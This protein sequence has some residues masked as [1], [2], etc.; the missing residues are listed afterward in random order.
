MKSSRLFLPLVCRVSI[1]TTVGLTMAL[2][3]LVGVSEGAFAQAGTEEAAEL[4]SSGLLAGSRGGFGN[5]GVGDTWGEGTKGGAPI[6]ASCN[7]SGG[8]WGVKLFNN[9]EDK[10]RV[11][12]KVKVYD[13]NNKQI[14][15]SLI[16]GTLTAK[17]SL[18]RTMRGKS[19]GV[20]CDVE[21]LSWKRTE[22]EK[23]QDEIN[24]E[25][26]AAKAKVQELEKAAGIDPSAS[27]AL[28]VR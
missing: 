6:T 20:H 16:S 22:K 4:P 28:L 11:S 24:S 1:K 26:E 12:V 15:S 7:N 2:A 18:D 5:T 25:L 17:S 3:G 21:L 13:S 23:S 9:S 8:S 10:Y 19:G 14:D 27:P